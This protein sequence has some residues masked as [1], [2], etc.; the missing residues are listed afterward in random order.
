LWRQPQIEYPLSIFYAVSPFSFTIV[1][2]AR[3]TG[4]AWAALPGEIA[5]RF[6]ATATVQ[7]PRHFSPR[8]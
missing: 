8:A 5:Q 2:V 6:R 3:W 4:E 1:F 7:S